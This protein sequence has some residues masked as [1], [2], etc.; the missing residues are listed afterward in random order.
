MCMKTRIRTWQEKYA[1]SQP[2]SNILRVYVGLII[3]K[4]SNLNRKF[5]DARHS[6]DGTCA[7]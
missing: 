7:N 3:N 2:E 6:V 1:A 4:L 5:T